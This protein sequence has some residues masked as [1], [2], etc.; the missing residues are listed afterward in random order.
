MYALASLQ[1]QLFFKPKGDKA[2][3]VRRN[4]LYK[5]SMI[6]AKKIKKCPD[7]GKKLTPDTTLYSTYRD[8]YISSAHP[9][10]KL[11]VCKK[12]YIG[13]SLIKGLYEDKKI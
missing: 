7:C 9:Q 10:G 4:P 8:R 13:Q 1:Y 6:K 3:A 5:K 11:F 12:C 2:Q